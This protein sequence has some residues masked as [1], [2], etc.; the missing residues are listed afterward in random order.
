[1]DFSPA[2]KG[3]CVTREERGRGMLLSPP[4]LGSLCGPRKRPEYEG[5][6]ERG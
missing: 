5:L 6:R 4:A 3:I 2:L 1:L